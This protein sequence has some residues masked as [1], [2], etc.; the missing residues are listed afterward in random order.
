V[1]SG[2]APGGTRTRGLPVDNR[3]SS[4]LDHEGVRCGR[5]PVVGAT[6]DFKFVEGSRSSLAQAS[7]TVNG[8]V[9]SAE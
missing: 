8:T 1:S 7:F 9:K 2:S 4:P 6:P 3:A 5:R